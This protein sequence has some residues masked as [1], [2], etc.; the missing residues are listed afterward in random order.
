MKKKNA[1]ALMA[2]VAMIVVV[3]SGC[4]TFTG[5]ASLESGLKSNWSVIEPDFREYVAADA[6]LSDAE[7]ASRLAQ[8]NEFTLRLANKYEGWEID[9]LWAAKAAVTWAPLPPLIIAYIEG[10]P[11]I[12]D[13]HKKIRKA[14][15]T[16]ITRLLQNAVE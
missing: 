8:A 11:S 4:A 9:E 7:K 1:I 13:T 10:D 3:A 16:T 2:L 6:A 5:N 15:V 12:N 14:S